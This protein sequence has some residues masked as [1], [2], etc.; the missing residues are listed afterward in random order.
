M[1][2][3]VKLQDIFYPISGV[4]VSDRVVSFSFGFEIWGE[5]KKKKM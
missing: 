5:E 3:D 2:S 4:S 1:S